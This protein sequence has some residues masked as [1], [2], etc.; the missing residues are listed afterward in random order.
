MPRIRKKT[1]KRGSTNQREK[2]KHKA[3]ETNKKRKKEAKKNPQW[4][5]K[6]E[7]DPGIPNNFPYKDQIL[8]EI[9]EERRRGAEEKEKRKQEK[10]GLKAQGD[11]EAGQDA[12]EAEG[13]FDGVRTLS[14][15][16]KEQTERRVVPSAVEVEEDTPMLLDPQL[17]DLKSVLDSADAVLQVL[18]SRDPLRCRSS[19]VDELSDGKKTALVLNKIDAC[20][21][22]AVSSWVQS[23]RGQHPTVLFRSA[24]AFLPS[25]AE[26]VGKGKEKERADDAWGVKSVDALLRQWAEEKTDDEPLVVAVVGVTNSGKSSFINSLLRKAVLPTYKLASGALD[27]PTTTTHAQE[28]TLDLDGKQ[29]RLIDTP[30]LAW[31][32]PAEE[33]EEEWQRLRA[34]DILTRNR[35]R[36]DRLKDP[37]LVVAK[38]ASRADREDL[39]LFYNLPAFTEGDGNAFLSGVARSNGFIKK[40]SMLDLAGASRLILRDWSTGKFPRYT[41]A[42]SPSPTS[43][44]PPASLADILARLPT[45]KEMRKAGGIVK[46]KAGESESRRVVLDVSWIGSNDSG[47]GS[48]VDEDEGEEGDEPLGEDASIDVEEESGDEEEESGDEDDD[49]EEED[50]SEEDEEARPALKGKRKRAAAPVLARPAKKVAFAPEPK[51][52]KQARSA[53]GGQSH[54]AARKARTHTQADDIPSTKPK[55]KVSPTPKAALAAKASKKASNTPAVKKAANAASK[56]TASTNDDEEAYDFKKFF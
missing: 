3:A 14:G 47:N 44:E 46:L 43:V 40:G 18:D 24:S 17:P 9:A 12:A 21:R 6:H 41:M 35:G 50:E 16:R 13:S 28:V 37:A 38:I 45:R 55:V 32:S 25:T 2:I 15:S 11:E 33:T 23:L 39:M 8:A 36:I 5:S 10:K 26:D 30:G 53:A 52:T 42:P 29:I 1:S 51:G 48:G 56:K 27:G 7:K 54:A 22:E 31:Q 4:K 20:P 19:H 49:D 34:G